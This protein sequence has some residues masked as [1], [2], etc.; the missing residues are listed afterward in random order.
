MESALL[1]KQNIIVK[2]KNGTNKIKYHT[3][4]QQRRSKDDFNM[5][6]WSQILFCFM[7]ALSRPNCKTVPKS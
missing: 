2:R 4:K 6:E 3:V 7:P 1:M 5:R